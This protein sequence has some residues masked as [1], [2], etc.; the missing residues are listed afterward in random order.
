MKFAKSS[1]FA[2][3]LFAVA[4]FV[5]AP[6]QAQERGKHPAYLRALD[7][8]RLMRAYIQ[9]DSPNERVDEESQHAIDEIDAAIHEIKEASIEDGKDLNYHPPID[10]NIG[11]GGRFRKAREAGTAAWHD[12]DK[13]EDNGFARGLKHRALDHIEKANHIVDHIMRRFDH[14]HDHDHDRDHDHDHM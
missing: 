14:D 2:F 3:A 8:L 5:A 13:E 11:P 1:L 7:D 6:S 12:V 4:A 10:A 9:P